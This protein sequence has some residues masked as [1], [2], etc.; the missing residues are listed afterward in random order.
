MNDLLKLQQDFFLNCKP[1]SSV[2]D[3]FYENF[4]TAAML[5]QE[6]LTIYRESIGLSLQ[7]ALE[8]TYPCCAHMLTAEPFQKL[9]QEFLSQQLPTFADLN[10]F[11]DHFADFLQQQINHIPAYVPDLASFVWAWLDV[12]NPPLG[13]QFNYLFNF[14][15]DAAS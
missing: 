5:N 8:S 4:S 10:Y 1:G 2:N 12:V 9:T 14:T 7:R 13:L 3:A 11:G 6:R 15:K